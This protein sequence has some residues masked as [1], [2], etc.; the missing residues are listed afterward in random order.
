MEKIKLISP[1]PQFW[2]HPKIKRLIKLG[3]IKNNNK[4]EILVEKTSYLEK[5]LDTLG[6]IWEEGLIED[7][8]PPPKPLY[9]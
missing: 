7:F 3:V 1:S 9:L 5:V 4:N 8:L 2:G 6:E